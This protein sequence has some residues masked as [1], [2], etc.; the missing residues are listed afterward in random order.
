MAAKKHKLWLSPL[1]LFLTGLLP[2]MFAQGVQGTSGCK[3][4]SELEA[5]LASQPSAAVYDALGAYFGNEHRIS[6]AISA[7]E[8]AILLN[9]Q[10]WQSYYDL[11]IILA[12]GDFARAVQELKTAAGLSPK[13]PQIHI[14]LG[15]A[16]NHMGRFDEAISE[17]KIVL[18]SDPDC[19]PA[20]TGITNALIAEKR[21]VA[22][23]TYLKSA[24]PNDLL[25]S[26]LAAAY[27]K[28]GNRNEAIQEW[29]AIVQRDPLDA[30]AHANLALAYTGQSQYRQASVEFDEA[31]HLDP[32]D[33]SARI[34]FVTVLVL[35]AQYARAL[36]V[37]QDYVHRNPDNFRGLYLAGV[38]N[39]KLGN[40]PNAEA[41][42]RRAIAI[43]STD[44]DARYCLGYVLLRRGK[45]PEARQQFETALQFDPGSEKTRFQLATVLRLLGEPDKARDELEIFER[46]KVEETRKDRALIAANQ[47]SDYF[48]VGEGRKASDL[49]R[50]SIAQDPENARTYYDLALALDMLHDDHGEQQALEKSVALDPELAPAHN[51]LGVLALRLGHPAEGEA[52][53]RRA[54][55]LDPQYAEARNN[56]GVYYGQLGRR[57]E[58]EQMFRQATEDD[59]SFGAAF[60]NLGLILASQSRLAQAEEA[61][62]RALKLSPENAAV[63]AASAIVSKGLAQEQS[64]HGADLQ[65]R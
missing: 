58:A 13:T 49:C 60:M 26:T 16:L 42:L 63:V 14:D 25:Q 61:L 57:E 3:G 50:E 37:I 54:I 35:V 40:Y 34:S 55:S 23:I 12:K 52:E 64:G 53:F 44:G 31:L 20:L 22:A 21:Y 18:Q 10:G 46:K 65:S 30:A 11:A 27:E 59:P 33:D 32:T 2:S 24:P 15:S 39:Q 62:E 47:A 45:L 7:F 38:V 19:V 1:L 28:N 9:P 48:A 6:C 36:P 43:N 4:S 41:V 56:L 29:Y 8:S 5:A 17:F 51:R